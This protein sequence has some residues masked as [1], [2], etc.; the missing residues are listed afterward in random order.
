MAQNECFDENAAPIEEPSVNA[1]HFWSLPSN[2]ML[3]V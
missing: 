2:W 1:V 3:T